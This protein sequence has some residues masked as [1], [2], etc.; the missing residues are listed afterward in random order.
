MLSTFEPLTSIIVGAVVYREAITVKAVAGIFC[1]LAA[2]L[3]VAGTELK[4]DKNS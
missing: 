1:I 4:T 3:M 2:V